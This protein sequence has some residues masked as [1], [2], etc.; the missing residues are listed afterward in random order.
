MIPEPSAAPAP[1]ALTPEQYDGR[2]G[3]N[4]ALRRLD[5][6]L[7]AGKHPAEPEMQLLPHRPAGDV[8]RDLAKFAIIS[9]LLFK[10]K[11]NADV[12]EALREAGHGC[13]ER[14]LQ[15]IMQR[16]DFLDYYNRFRNQLMEPIDRQVRDDLKLAMP[17]ALTK[18]ISLMRSARSEK[19]QGEMAVRILEG[20]GGITK[21]RTDKKFIFNVPPEL[22]KMMADVGQRLAE[23]VI[24]KPPIEAEAIKE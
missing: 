12:L 19:V 16:S 3:E 10:N 11:S 22:Q 17:E 9:R 20:G 4:P 5:A 21:E 6:A 7:D 15:R 23:G 24:Q 18:M 1:D 8:L 13:S 2:M 14:T